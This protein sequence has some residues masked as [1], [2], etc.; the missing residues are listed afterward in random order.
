MWRLLPK[1]A[2]RVISYAV[3]FFQM[4]IQQKEFTEIEEAHGRVGL[5]G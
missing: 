3:G 2:E 4:N 1:P 5:A